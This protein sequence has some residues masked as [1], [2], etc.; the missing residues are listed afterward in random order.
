MALYEYGVGGNEVKQDVNESIQ[1]IASNRTLLL[2][3]LT[4]EAPFAPEN[5]YGLKTMKMVFE[6][7]KPKSTLTFETEDGVTRKEEIEFQT[8][9][10]FKAK[11]I[12][13]QSGHLSELNV[14]KEQYK[15][16]TKQLGSNRA[17]MKALNDDAAKSAIIDVIKA[18]LEELTALDKEDDED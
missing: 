18:A 14:Q 8:V 7:F 1:N 3:Q 15:Q 9:G 5:V 11:N 12:V 16:I 6:H 10:D 4:E 17:L 2:Q 13:K